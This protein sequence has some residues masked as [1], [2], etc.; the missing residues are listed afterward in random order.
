M[1]NFI[2]DLTINVILAL[3]LHNRVLTKKLVANFKQHQII[4]LIIMYSIFYNIIIIYYII[5]LFVM[6]LPDS[7]LLLYKTI[8]LFQQ[9]EHLSNIEVDSDSIQ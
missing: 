8:H 1:Y 3:I 9:Y 7:V 4:I 5:S 2:H 6:Y